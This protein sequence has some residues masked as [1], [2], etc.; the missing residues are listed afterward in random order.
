ML[1][2]TVLATGPAPFPFDG[3]NTDL[4]IPRITDLKVPNLAA[5]GWL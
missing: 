3:V 5:V 2:E 4:I 1:G